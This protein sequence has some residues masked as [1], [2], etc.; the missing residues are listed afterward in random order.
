MIFIKTSI[1]SQSVF[2]MAS[3]ICDIAIILTLLNQ[4]CDFVISKK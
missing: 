4:I 3:Q 1:L 2:D